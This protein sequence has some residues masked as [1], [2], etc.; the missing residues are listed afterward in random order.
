MIDGSARTSQGFQP[1]MAPLI[2]NSPCAYVDLPTAGGPDGVSTV[3]QGPSPLDAALRYAAVGWYVFPIGTDSKVPLTSRGH[4]DATTDEAQIKSWWTAHPAARIGVH[5][6]ASGL[7]VVDVDVADGKP[8]AATFAALEAAHGALPRTNHQRSGRGGEHIV[9]RD[10]SPG[11]TGWTRTHDSGGA[12]RG[13]LGPG[14]DVK[15]NGYIVVEP[16]GDYR[17]LAL[18]PDKLADVPEAW[19]TLMRKT[20]EE[21]A[22]VGGSVEQWSESTHALDE[23]SSDRLRSMLDNLGPRGAGSNTTFQAIKLVCHAF[24]QSVEDGASYLLH[25]NAGCGM[26]HSSADLQRQIERVATVPDDE[27][28]DRGRGWI[29]ELMSLFSKI[30]ES[31]TRP[32]PGNENVPAVTDTEA[33]ATLA[34]VVP[35]RAQLGLLVA[36]VAARDKPPIR[37]YPTGLADLDRLLGGGISTR[38]LVSVLGPPGA[39]KTAWAV[40]HAIHMQAQ[41]PVLYISTELEADELMARVAGVVLDCPWRDIVRGRVDR[42]R[43]R[44]SLAGLR[45]RI[46]G[47]DELPRDGTAIE[48]FATTARAMSAE[49]GTPPLLIVDY[50][51]DLARGTDEKNLRA[52]IGDVATALRALAQQLDCPLIAIS[53]VSRAYYSAKRQAEMRSA[54]DPTVYLAAAKESGDVDYASAAVLFLDVEPAGL[55]PHRLAQVAVA[56][57]RH[58]ETGFAGARFYAASGRWQSDPGAVSALASAEREDDAGVQL[59]RDESKV[60]AAV[61]KL[62]ALGPDSYGRS[63]LLSKSDLKGACGVNVKRANDAIGR[64]V[65]SGRL[66]QREEHFQER[67]LRNSHDRERRNR[68]IVNTETAAS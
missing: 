34:C 16:S 38:Q 23:S 44:A 61:T 12:C 1:V 51:Q 36:D 33:P 29:P 55:Q 42:E 6:R 64:L 14:V 50:M 7:I 56:K 21:C 18:D 9:M 68:G 19:T 3:A 4:L 32:A 5:C 53:S 28:Q 17:W 25:W 10:P 41:L 46:V 67:C 62:K 13:K 37:S 11:P 20:P 22:L 39:G 52:K 59:A 47:C 49:Y 30:F 60:M 43:V 65:T 8:G 54:Q 26:P 35:I 45:I 40:A 57:Q 2:T 24:G 58:G 31:K 15:S 66:V 63:Q 48:A 27:D